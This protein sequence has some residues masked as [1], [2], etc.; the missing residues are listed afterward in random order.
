MKFK[1]INLSIV[2][3][4]LLFAGSLNIAFAEDNVCSTCVKS[5]AKDTDLDSCKICCVSECALKEECSSLEGQCEEECK[6]D[7]D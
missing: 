2:F 7:L 5:C 3:S 1:F 4:F 6:K